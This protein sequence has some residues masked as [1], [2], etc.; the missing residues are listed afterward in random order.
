MVVLLAEDE[1]DGA[2]TTLPAIPS[3]TMQLKVSMPTRAI[4][5]EQPPRPRRAAPRGGLTRPSPPVLTQLHA[6][7]P[8]RAL[9]TNRLPYKLLPRTP[10]GMSRSRSTSSGLISSGGTSQLQLLSASESSALLLPSASLPQLPRS[11][12]AASDAAPSETRPPDALAPSAAAETQQN[13]Q[14]QQN[15]QTQQMPPPPPPRPQQQKAPPPQ[16]PPVPPPQQ[17]VVASDDA[18]S[19]A[20]AK[21]GGGRAE[22]VSA[23]PHVDLSA[24]ARSASAAAPSPPALPLPL[25][26]NRERIVAMRRCPLLAGLPEA[27]LQQLAASAVE[28]ECK[29]YHA[30]RPTRSVCVLVHGGFANKEGAHVSLTGPM[31]TELLTTAPDP[32][33]ASAA[34]AVALECAV[35]GE[36]GEAGATLGLAN[37]LGGLVT[38]PVS[39]LATQPSL[40]LQLPVDA[41]LQALPPASLAALGTEARVRM[42]LAHPAFVEL[43]PP[44]PAVRRLAALTRL[45]AAQSGARLFNAGE[46]CEELRILLSGRVDLIEAGGGRILR[47]VNATVTPP[48]GEAPRPNGEPPPPQPYGAAAAESGCLLLCGGPEAN[49]ALQGVLAPQVI[50]VADSGAAGRG[51]G[52]GGG[53]GAP[54]EAMARAGASGPAIL[55]IVMAAKAAGGGGG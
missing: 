41:L 21:R 38:V 55:S 32:A 10:R 47:T 22:P 36:A 25:L 46:A 42:L 12:S 18:T 49:E 15:P 54:A 39:F 37:L 51:G 26:R 2:A 16:P 11:G 3:I 31:P 8:A 9:P 40:L 30:L 14:T 4:H 29:K 43:S 28:K 7:D 34:S 27:A 13:S 52:P 23:Q 50:D 45:V 6:L 5:P 20:A 1:E 33:T 24:E 17:E 53:G 48:L 19:G 44:V 35:A